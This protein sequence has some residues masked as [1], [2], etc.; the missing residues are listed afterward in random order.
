MK[1]S[2][3]DNYNIIYIY[4]YVTSFAMNIIFYDAVYII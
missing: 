3:I 4:I 1:P 2:H